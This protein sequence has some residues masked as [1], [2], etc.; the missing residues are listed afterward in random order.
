MRNIL[1]DFSSISD[2]LE[3]KYGVPQG[4]VIGPILFLLYVNDISICVKE[5]RVNI[6]VIY[7]IIYITGKNIAD[8]IVKMNL[9]LN[10]IF[11]WLCDN[12]LRVNINKCKYMIIGSRNKLEHIDNVKFNVQH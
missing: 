12:S 10:V 7:T 9:E 3:T 6:F 1:L 4:T 2:A 8:M 11:E 5:C